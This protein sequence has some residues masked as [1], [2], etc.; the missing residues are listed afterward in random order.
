[1]KFR[2]MDEEQLKQELYH[3]FMNPILIIRGNL[4]LAVRD[5]DNE[6]QIKRLERAL[7]ALRRLENIV[8]NMIEAGEIR[9]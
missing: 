3:F 6:E 1:M 8:H 5:A 4:R 2:D 7:H 9:E